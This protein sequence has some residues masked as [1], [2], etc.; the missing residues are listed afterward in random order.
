MDSGTELL[1]RVRGSVDVALDMVGRSADL[2]ELREPS[3]GSRVLAGLID[4]ADA[5]AAVAVAV[6][7]ELNK[8][9]TLGPA[10]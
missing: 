10:A 7:E 4:A 3:L 9:S 8:R 6:D 2:Y 5:L 1:H